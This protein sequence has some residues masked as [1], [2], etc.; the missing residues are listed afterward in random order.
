[1]SY[2]NIHDKIVSTELSLYIYIDDKHVSTEHPMSYINIHDKLVSTEH[3]MSYIYIDDN[4][5]V[6]RTSNVVHIHS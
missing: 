4:T 5:C 2:R 3:P 1:M 6:N